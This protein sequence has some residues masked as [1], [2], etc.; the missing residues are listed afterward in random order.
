MLEPDAAQLE[1]VSRRVRE[2]RNGRQVTRYH[3]HGIHEYKGKFNPQ[4]VRSF[5]NQLEVQP[6]D[7]LVDPFCGSGTALLEGLS[8][9]TNVMG[10]D[11]S[12]MA[13]FLARSKVRA[14]QSADP[15]RLART[16]G[17]WIDH[18]EEDVTAAQESATEVSAG[19]S[20]IDRQSVDYLRRW[21]TPGALAGLSAA[22]AN[23]K[24]ISGTANLLAGVAISSLCRN[25]SLQAPEDLRIRRRPSGFDAPPLA[26][27]L[28]A[29]VDEVMLGLCE[30]DEIGLDRT[31][32]A[33]V[34]LGSASAASIYQP[35]REARRRV[36][37]SSPPYAT[38]LP[39]IDTDRLSIALLGLSSASRLATLE[40]S[41]FGS[42]EWPIAEQRR[43][44][45]AVQTNERGLPA[46]IASLCIRLAIA[47]A[48]G[49]F[50]RRALPG[51]LYRYFVYMREAFRS[52]RCAMASGEDAVFIVG[53]NRTNT[54]EGPVDIRTPD[55]LAV[56]SEQVGFCVNELVSLDTFPRF[57][58][59]HANGINQESAI[60]LKAA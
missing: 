58:L 54:V 10:V 35:L 5:A 50:R 7:W 14:F 38:A 42:R 13:T 39:Y 26:A 29:A 16:L 59:H 36:V 9:G 27:L 43:W 22:F 23:R 12:P 51:L 53:S 57:G 24:Q 21:F 56:L 49:G 19:L 30:L 8:L 1:A 60:H 41:L 17:K 3:L 15:K 33:L 32:R 2:R 6:G 37:I 48:N 44:A 34:R 47:H 52:L 31:G 20:H 18:T 40:R 25:V 46:I 4:V 11:K 55:L 45:D 28:R